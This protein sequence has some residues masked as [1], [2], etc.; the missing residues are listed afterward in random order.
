M[1]VGSY[2][3]RAEANL[4]SGNVRAGLLA[5]G[6][7]YNVFVGNRVGT[8]ASG[9]QAIPNDWIGVYVNASFTR[10]GGTEAGDGN[11]VSGNPSGIEVGGPGIV[12]NLVLGN[13]IGTDSG[14]TQPL[15]N[16]Y[17]GVSLGPGR[18][19]V[20]GATAAERNVISGNAW[21][22]GWPGGMTIAGGYHLVAG[23]YIGAD[24]S[25]TVAVGNRGV[26]IWFRGAEHSFVQ[27]NLIAHNTDRGIYVESDAFNTLRRNAIYDHTGQGIVLG[28]G[29][30]MLPA[31]VIL[32]VTETGVSGTACPGCTIEVFSDAEDEG[33]IYEGAAIADAVG[34]FIFDKGS[35]LTG[36][37]LTAT[38]T[39]GAGNTSEFSTPV[40]RP[41]KVYL[42]LV[43]K[44]HASHMGR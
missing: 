33:R 38:A 29:N 15:P 14:G 9:T 34:H 26:G 27:G 24:P 40:A 42:P 18:A 7:D 21:P 17:A 31:P 22:D 19:I 12:G 16:A 1:E 43:L 6:G 11:L 39:D 3:N 23:N 44:S 20:G 35:P 4:S 13:L 8:D 32:T 36:P 2:H 37:Y 28:G 30:Q 5:D 25:G 10:I 41:V